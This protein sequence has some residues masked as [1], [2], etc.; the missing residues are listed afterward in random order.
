MK[1]NRNYTKNIQRRIIYLVFLFA[2]MLI[3]GKEAKA[4]SYAAWY[5]DAQ[6]RIDTLRKGDFGIKI[7]DKDGNPFTGDVSVRMKK[8]EFP[9]GMA[10]DF[11]EG[12]ASMGNSYSTTAAVQAVSDAKI[13]QSERWSDYLAYAIPAESGKNYKLTLKFAEIYFGSGNSRVFNVK[14]ENQLFL[15]NYDVYTE[16]GGKNIAVDTA[17]TILATD[18]Q[19]NIELTSVTD[20]VAI[21]GIQLE[22]I[23]GTQVTRINCGGPE[24][25]TGDGNSYQSEQGFFDPDVNTV[26]SGE[27]WMK[28]TMYKYFNYGVTGNS[29]KWSGVQPNHTTPNYSNFENALRWTQKVGWKLRGHNLLWGGDDAHST[30]DW[31]RNLP[32]TEAFVDT[33]KM[34]IIRDVS[35]YKGLIS[36]YD[37]VNEPLSGHAD[38]MRNTHGDSIIW[39]SFKWARSADPDADLYVNDYNVEYNWGQAAE[40]RDLILEIIENGGPIT[41]VGMQAHFWDCCRPNVDELIKN[42]NI[43]AEAGLP[44]RLTEYDFGGNLTEEE[45]AEDLI[46]VLTIAF[47]HPSVNGMI[48]WVLRD[49]DNEDGWRPKSGYFNFDYTPKLAADTL[50]YYTKKLWATNFDSQISSTSPLDFNAYYGDYEIEV[51]FGDSVKVFTI[52]CLKENEDSVFT[53]YESNAKLKGPQLL[54]A[55]FEADNVVKLEFD[56]PIDNSSLVRSQFKFFSTDGIGLDA[57]EADQYNDKAIL[58]QLDRNVNT[59]DYNTVAYF[60]GSLKATD[61]SSA[62][63]FG[64]KKIGTP[65]TQVGIELGKDFDNEL[66]VFPNPATTV[67]NIEYS[68]APY[69]V[70]VYNS[71]GVLVHSLESSEPLININIDSYTKGLYL[72]RITDNDNNVLT[73][74]VIVN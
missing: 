71:I 35:R 55:T 56:K 43:I 38:W 46:K 64:P 5:R 65:D 41:G 29:F 52:P 8:H 18:N 15:Q 36:E 13:Y 3:L 28:A 42:I 60:P 40:Y 30:P 4:Q 73:R 67:L 68:E 16:A 45:Q 17:L 23:G 26:A 44:I 34:R 2:A 24:L 63:A 54:N 72:V 7:I 48:S 10:F 47:S 19:I 58:L 69:K 33:C 1:Y 6:E 50:L 49:S 70:S 27:Q 51:A 57:V 20:N 66:R 62:E 59:D 31:V 53:L 22:E 39:N 21:K 11:Y 14:V 32:T 37:V 61:G 74:K 9:F 12:E 25:T